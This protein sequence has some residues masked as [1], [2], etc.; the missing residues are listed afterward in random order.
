MKEFSLMLDFDG[1]LTDIEEETKE[2]QEIYPILFLEKFG[3]K[4]SKYLPIFNEIKEELKSDEKKGF[5]L[6]GQDVLPVSSDPYILTQA[7]SQE[8]IKREKL[9]VEDETK[10]IIGLFGE[11]LKKIPKQN[12]HYRE[13]KEK[14]KEFLDKTM[15]KYNLVFVTNS[16]R[17]KVEHYLKE[18]GSDYFCNISVIGNAKKLFVNP[19]FDE[20]PES[21]TPPNFKRE[22]LLRR[23]NYYGILKFLSLGIFSNKNTKVIGDIYELDLAL[24]D[25]L[26]YD[27]IQMENGYSKKHERDY[28]GENFVK[29]YNELENLLL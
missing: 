9:L 1:T 29:N 16:Q 15:R 5:I 8:M 10:T 17:G 12:A 13:G 23:D 3:L 28:L 22:V 21:F 11:T 14:T 2:F 7:T 26:G 4:K 25:Y 19:N 20:V 27:V 6:N 18:L 24:P